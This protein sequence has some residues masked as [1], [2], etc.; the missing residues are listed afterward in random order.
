MRSLDICNPVCAAFTDVSAIRDKAKN[1]Q[2]LSSLQNPQKLI[3]ED[4]LPA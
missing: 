2:S 3:R 1:N 4:L